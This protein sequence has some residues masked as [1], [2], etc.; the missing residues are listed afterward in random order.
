MYDLTV[1]PFRT[2]SSNNKNIEGPIYKPR[3][4]P[5][6]SKLFSYFR[7]THIEP[8]LKNDVYVMA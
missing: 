5:A 2:P 6:S 3:Y 4:P 1:S 7:K 8:V